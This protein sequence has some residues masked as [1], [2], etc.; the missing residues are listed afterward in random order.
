MLKKFL[1]SAAAWAC[2]SSSFAQD[3]SET[4]SKLN[5][6]GSADVYYRFNLSNP[7]KS[8]GTFNNYTS[9]TN[10]QNSFELGMASVKLEHALGKA[11]MV[12]DLGFGKRAEEFSYNDNNTMLAIKQLYISYAPWTNIKFTVGSWAT[13]IGYELVDAYANRNYS[14]SYMFSKGPF[15]HTGL[16]A[17]GSFGKSGLMLGIADPT[18]FKSANFSRKYVIAQYSI[19]TKNDKFKAYLNFQAGKPHDSA[20]VNQFDLVLTQVVTDKFNIAFDGTVASTQMKNGDKYADAHS[21]WGTAI[22]LNVD[23]KSWLGF[24]LREELFNDEKQLTDVF[25]ANTSGGKVFASTL[26]A[27]FRISNLTIIPEVRLDNASKEI[28]VKESGA[29]TKNTATLL[30]AAV[31]KFQ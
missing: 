8:S 18:D 26:S 11:N 14:M 7:P 16:K 27:N 6:T 1:A 2:V 30:L 24:T 3:S 13:H 15:F 22:Y 28:F 10:S 21:W 5:I 20:R 23:P 25:Y 31:Y 12:A 29:T 4:K 19:A 9:F 17:E